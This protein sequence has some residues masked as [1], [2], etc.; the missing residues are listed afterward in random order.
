MPKVLCFGSLN[1]DY[2]Y[3]VDHFVQKGETTAATALHVNSGG[4]GLNQSCALA[5]AGCRVFHAGMIG[6][7]GRFLLDVLREAAA[8]VSLVKISR[9]VRTGNAIIQNDREGDNCII[10]FG[11]SNRQITPEMADEVL[12]HFS[13]GDYIILQNEISSLAYIIQKASSLGMVTVLNASP[14]DAQ[15]TDTVLDAA[16]W[17]LMNE[18]E[19]AAI[20]GSSSDSEDVL[21]RALRE[22]FPGKRMVLT[23][24]MNGSCYID[25]AETIHQDIFPAHTVDTTAAGDTFTGYFISGILQ[26]KP[27]PEC[28]RLASRASSIAVS[29]QGAAPSIPWMKEVM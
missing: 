19:A 17:I 13:R 27:I 8:D 11:G 2:V 15:L 22:R 4:K 18:I 25:D 14:V 9:E 20:T 28:L 12:S 26:G 1:I 24:G 10:L 3:S 5:K 6:E 23:L 16:D 29:R 21:I 7:D